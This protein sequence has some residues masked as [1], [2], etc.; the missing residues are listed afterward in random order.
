MWRGSRR[1]KWGG[2]VKQLR[3]WLFTIA[4]AFFSLVCI[5]ALGIW[6]RSYWV[7]DSISADASSTNPTTYT[8]I[9]VESGRGEIEYFSRHREW[10]YLAHTG[11]SAAPGIRGPTWDRRPAND[12]PD[13]YYTPDRIDPVIRW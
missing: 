10:R 1:C 4:A 9:F 5:A 8:E 2:N 3:Q 6:V 11:A 13:E 12:L 7:L